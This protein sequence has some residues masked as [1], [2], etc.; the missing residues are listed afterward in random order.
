MHSELSQNF[1]LFFEG[2]DGWLLRYGLDVDTTARVGHQV[3]YQY[4]TSDFNY[5]TIGLMISRKILG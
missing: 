1:V 3:R 5:S 2:N 4:C